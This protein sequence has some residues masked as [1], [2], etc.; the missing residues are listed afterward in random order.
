MGERSCVQAFIDQ[1]NDFSPSFITP[2]V[3]EALTGETELLLSLSD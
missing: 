1:V 3:A 2:L